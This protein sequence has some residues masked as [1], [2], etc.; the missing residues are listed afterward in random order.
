MFQADIAVST[1][2]ST[3][4]ELLAVGTPIVCQPVAENQQTIAET[5]K[6]R[7]MA[8]VVN[9]GEE[10]PGFRRSIDRYMSDASLRKRY[11]EAGRELVDAYGTDR[12]YHKITNIN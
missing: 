3:T 12:I 10:N 2:S 5:L 9:A 6:N 8:S 4:Y 7:D 1:A 11:S